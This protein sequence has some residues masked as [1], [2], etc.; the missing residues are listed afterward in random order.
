MKGQLGPRFDL[1]NKQEST[2]PTGDGRCRSL[3]LA[4]RL[5][6]SSPK[7]ACSAV[8][9]LYLQCAL[10][11]INRDIS[12][13]RKV[14][15]TRLDMKSEGESTWGA[16]GCRVLRY[17]T[18]QAITHSA[19]VSENFQFTMQNVANRLGSSVKVARNSL[20]TTTKGKG[21]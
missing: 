10:E 14:T 11:H 19:P 15:A 9:H 17:A 6:Q 18:T 12:D 8:V 13:S 2:A 3:R 21:T 5:R 7:V 20:G 4:A 1:R 16:C